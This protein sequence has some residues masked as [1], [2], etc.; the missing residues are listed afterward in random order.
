MSSSM[1]AWLDQ[2]CKA[3]AIMAV[4]DII[5][6]GFKSGECVKGLAWVGMVQVRL[7]LILEGSHYIFLT[8][9]IVD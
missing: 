4:N 9:K 5:L 2:H 6:L 8:K 3:A 7:C 1:L